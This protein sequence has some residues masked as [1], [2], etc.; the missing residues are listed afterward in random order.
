[1][2]LHVVSLPHT[3][4]TRKYLHCAFTQNVVKFCDMMTAEGHE[5]ILYSGDENEAKCSEHVQLVD[6]EWRVEHFGAWDTN[7]TFGYMSWE[8]DSPAWAHFNAKAVAAISERAEPRDTVCIFSGMAQWP[9]GP[10]LPDLLTIEAAVGYNGFVPNMLHVFPSYAWMNYLYGGAG[11]GTARAFDAVIPHYF[12]PCDFMPLA[13]KHG[14]DDYLLFIGRITAGKGPKVAAEIAKRMNMRLVVAGPGAVEVDGKVI[15]EG[16][17]LEGV[18][19]AGP[20]DWAERASLMTDAA[21]TLVP[22]Q[23]IEPFGA[24]AVESMMCG[25]PVVSTD[26]GAFV[27]TVTPGVTGYRFRTLAEGVQATTNALD[28][29]RLGV[30]QHAEEHYSLSAI[31]PRYTEAIEKMQSLYGTGWYS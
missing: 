25:T 4:T 15:G 21:A 13:R 11:I 26:W 18:E 8:P 1:M 14:G 29:D 30:R 3:Q 12:D 7:S 23:Y 27:E 19:Y 20:V 10:A 31:G 6:E 9:I 24:V 17:E 16:V 28:L 22:T 5:V 2:R